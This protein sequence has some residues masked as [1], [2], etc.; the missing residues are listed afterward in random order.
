MSHPYLIRL[1]GVASVMLLVIS[2][3]RSDHPG[4][5]SIR[6]IDLG[7]VGWMDSSQVLFHRLDRVGGGDSWQT[8]CDSAGLYTAAVGGGV[9]S[10]RSDASTC[11][12]IRASDD[13]SL[14]P[15]HQRILYAE[16]DNGSLHVLDLRTGGNGPITLSCTSVRTPRWSPDGHRFAFAAVCSGFPTAAI[17]TANVDGSDIQLVGQP[18]AGWVQSYPSWSPDGRS[19]AMQEDSATSSMIIVL[20]VTDRTRRQLAPGV[21]PSW[22]AT[23][24]GIAYWTKPVTVQPSQLHIV[25]SD[26]SRDRV[27]F[28]DTAAARG[29]RNR[30]PMGPVAWSSNGSAIAFATA[31]GLWVIEADGTG[32]RRLLGDSGRATSE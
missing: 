17:Y 4:G 8:T 7:A 5:Q 23:G 15:D 26:G 12:V 30:W 25:A 16:N 6:R 11:A 9:R 13:L 3:A 21:L 24:A 29:V 2:C 18:R 31:S 20:S 32:Q 28:S 27:V 19:L 1:C 14:H 10:W 22:S